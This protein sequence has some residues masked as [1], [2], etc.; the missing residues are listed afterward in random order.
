MIF[1]YTTTSLVTE[2]AKPQQNQI[3]ESVF[4]VRRPHTWFS[5]TSLSRSSSFAAMRPLCSV[6]AKCLISSPITRQ[7]KHYITTCDVNLISD[8]A[9]VPRSFRDDWQFNRVSPFMI[10]PSINSRGRHIILTECSPVIRWDSCPA[11]LSDR[12]LNTFLSCCYGHKWRRKSMLV[13]LRQIWSEVINKLA[14]EVKLTLIF[15]EAYP[16]CTSL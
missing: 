1:Q 5:E 10:T 14:K 12:H 13:M 6:S 2:Q 11:V 15:E 4:S 9:E 16:I 3:K 8:T 7:G